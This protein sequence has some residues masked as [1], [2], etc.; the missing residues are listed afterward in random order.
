[1]ASA[2]DATKKAPRVASAAD[3]HVVAA[4]KASDTARPLPAIAP[5]VAAAALG[6]DRPR[7]LRAVAMLDRALLGD[8]RVGDILNESSRSDRSRLR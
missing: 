6:G 8:T 3:R 1:M 4:R 2:D 7:N 5:A